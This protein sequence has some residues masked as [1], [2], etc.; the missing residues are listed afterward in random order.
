M[1]R[2]QCPWPPPMLTAIR[3]PPQGQTRALLLEQL[4]AELRL[5]R[6]SRQAELQGLR[7]ELDACK[8]QQKEAQGQLRQQEA[9]MAAQ[10]RDLEHQLQQCR[11]LQEEVGPGRERG[12]C[13]GRL[14]PDWAPYGNACGPHPDHVAPTGAAAGAGAGAAAGA[15]AGSRGAFGCGRGQLQPVPGEA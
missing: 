15:A 6:E 3:S 9:V 7:Q 4:Q 13:P 1:D 12:L 10:G 11:G 14:R 8:G 2:E 5:S